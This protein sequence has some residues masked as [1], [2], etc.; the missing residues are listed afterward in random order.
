MAWKNTLDFVS[1]GSRGTRGKR[2]VP[3]SC[4]ESAEYIIQCYA[5][6]AI[7][8]WEAGASRKPHVYATFG[9]KR[10]NISETENFH[11]LASG[12]KDFDF[13]GTLPGEG[14]GIICLNKTSEDLGYNM[15]LGA[16][17]AVDTEAK[18]ILISN[19][20]E[21]AHMAVKMKTIDYI[22]LASP[23]EFLTINFEEAAVKYAIGLL[24]V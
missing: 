6:G 9:N 5:K 4:I 15:H 13:K 10:F 24:S 3:N 14:S 7:L 12:I 8:D 2:A 1:L 19:M 17:V 18:K 23:E 16:V 20:M 11:L 21:P 22:E